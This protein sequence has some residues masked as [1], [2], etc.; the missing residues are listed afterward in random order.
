MW[1]AA[2]ILIGVGGLLLYFRKRTQDRLLDI[3]FVKTSSIAETLDE[4]RAIAAE[5]G[6]GGYAQ[7]KEFKGTVRCDAP[8]TGELSGQP[9][10]YYTMSVEERYEET[11]TERDSQGNTQTRTRTGSAV[12]ASNTQHTRFLLDDGSGSIA[13]DFDGA[14]VDACKVV[15]RYEPYAGGGGSLRVGSFT[16]SL[17]MSGG[18]RRVL[19]YQY[20]ESIV[21]LGQA[22]YALGEVND[23]GG[24]PVLRRPSDK[25]APF[26][27]SIKSE[28]ELTR[29]SERSITFLLWGAV[30]CFVIGAVLLALSF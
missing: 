19:G 23:S 15:E 30:G 10:V 27:L 17:G 21:P 6:P 8:L 18:P 5:L 7:Q 11:Y 16:L 2:I 13:V 20:R 22:L 9:C 29:D 3:R 4:Q 24:E 25:K 1:I 12:V 28:E 26:I 14:S